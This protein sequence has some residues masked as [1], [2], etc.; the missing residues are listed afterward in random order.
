MA[1]AKYE[2]INRTIAKLSAEAG[3]EIAGKPFI[4]RAFYALSF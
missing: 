1:P 4:N 3:H 2:W